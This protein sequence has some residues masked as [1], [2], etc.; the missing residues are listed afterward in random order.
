MLA[1]E[2]LAGTAQS[3]GNLIQ[4]Q[5]RTMAVASCPDDL[6]VFARGNGGCAAHCLSND[7]RHVAFFLEN[8]FDIARALERALLPTTP[9]TT[10]RVGRRNVFRAWKKR[11][12]TAAEHG[13]ASH[14][15]CVERGAMKRVPHGDSLVSSCGRACQFQ[16][17]ADGLGAA[18]SKQDLV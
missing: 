11:A 8:I 15:D 7:G 1:N 6:P 3:V 17:H 14:R 4:N 16:C 9:R 10:S 2:H 5:Q 12:D 13:F 18:W